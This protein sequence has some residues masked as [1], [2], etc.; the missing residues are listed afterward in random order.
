[1]N[2]PLRSPEE[3]RQ[4]FQ[5]LTPMDTGQF[6]AYLN[7]RLRDDPAPYSIRR[8]DPRDLPSQGLP[9]WV[10]LGCLAVSIGIGI[11]F[12]LAKILLPAGH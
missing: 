9:L 1:M 5:E 6:R 7:C 12:M 8:V 4:Q 2:T 3:V 10:S 11:G